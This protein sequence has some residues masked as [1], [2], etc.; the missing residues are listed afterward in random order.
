M[1]PDEI[2]RIEPA[3]KGTYYGGFFTPSD[4]TGDI[5]K[6]TRGLADVEQDNL[7]RQIN[8][9]QSAGGS[10]PA[11]RT[12]FMKVFHCPSD[13][14]SALTFNVP[15]G[16]MYLWCQLAPKV[17]ARTVQDLALRESVMVL[18]GNPFYVD[19]GGDHQL[20]VCYTSQPSGRSAQA[21]KTLARSIVSAAEEPAD[22]R[23]SVR[24]V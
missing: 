1:T 21:A 16:G 13:P 23:A 14:S 24:V 20:R 22:A 10:S 5:H 9:K 7:M 2:R 15:D 18:T 4:A 6:F 8:Y 19:Q 11:I 12:N 17:R 3:L